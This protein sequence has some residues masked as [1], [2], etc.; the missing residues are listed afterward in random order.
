MMM[1]HKLNHNYVFQSMFD[2]EN[3]MKERCNGNLFGDKIF[4]LGHFDRNEKDLTCLHNNYFH[5]LY[6]YL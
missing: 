4:S 1:I 3:T 6:T 2:L 5:S